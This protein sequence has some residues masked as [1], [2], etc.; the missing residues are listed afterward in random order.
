MKNQNIRIKEIVTEVRERFVA[1]Q[2]SRDVLQ[3]LY[4]QYN[5]SVDAVIFVAEAER[6]FPHL[7]CGLAT[8]YLRAI[9]GQGRVRQGKYADN[10]HTFLLLN[11]DMV[12]DITA[13][14]YG[15]PKVYVGK[16]EFPW[17]IP[18]ENT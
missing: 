4:H 15:G 2:V 9:L 1:R 6:M 11:G 13:D 14:Q 5:P 16:L 12:V 18:T 7:N 3:R 17:S 8:V 10:N